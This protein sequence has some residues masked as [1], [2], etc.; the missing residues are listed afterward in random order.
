MP[1]FECISGA[2]QIVA[3]GP[4]EGG[5]IVGGILRGKDRNRSQKGVIGGAGATRTV[6]GDIEIRQ[7][8]RRS[9]A[10]SDQREQRQGD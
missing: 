8:D 7:R 4:E 2:H 1:A 5:D 6:Q 3:V 9:D 10:N